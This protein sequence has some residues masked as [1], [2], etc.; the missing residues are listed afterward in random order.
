MSNKAKILFVCP[1]FPSFIQ[2]DLDILRRLFDVRVAR[3]QGK[4]RMLK[5][6]VETLKGVSWADVTFSWTG[7]GYKV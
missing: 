1:S 6:L 5:I 2:N 3:Y 7:K 4:N